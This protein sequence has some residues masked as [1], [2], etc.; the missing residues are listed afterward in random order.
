[1]PYIV[2]AER[3]LLYLRVAIVVAVIA[4]MALSHR[5]WVSS[6]L[7]P[8]TPVF[9]FLKPIPLHYDALLFGAILLALALSAIT[10]RLIPM[11]AILAIVLTLYDQSR[12]QPWFFVSFFLLLGVAFASPN[13]CRLIVASTWFWSGIEKISL[14]MA[15]EHPLALAAAIA[16]LAIGLAL[17]N[18]KL[19][20]AAV[21]AAV[22]LP[23]ATR[24]PWNAAMAAFVVILFLKTSDSARQILSGEGAFHIAILLLFGVAPVLSFF[25]LWEV[26]AGSPNR[27]TIYISDTLLGRLPQG[28]ARFAHTEMPGLASIDIAEWSAAELNVPPRP[29]VRIYKSIARKLCEYADVRLSI[30]SRS[31]VGSTVKGASYTCAALKNR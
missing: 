24:D 7:Y 28:I 14:P 12:L 22:L 4:G 29:D 13:A 19:R 31:P 30:V 9:P 23:I 15:K 17:L 5:L 16:E 20:T 10:P 11:F 6:R 8:L 2:D 21:I 18:S 25:G 26:Y 27:G 3:R 1:V